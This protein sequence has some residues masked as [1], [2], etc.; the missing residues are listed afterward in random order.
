MV[1]V[2]LDVPDKINLPPLVHDRQDT[3]GGAQHRSNHIGTLKTHQFDMRRPGAGDIR[4]LIENQRVFDAPLAD[5]QASSWDA[6][7]GVHLAIRADEARSQFSEDGA[8]VTLVP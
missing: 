8:D 7:I 6:E 1:E 5:L 2:N 4:S 3:E